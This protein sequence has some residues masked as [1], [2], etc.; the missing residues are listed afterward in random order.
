MSGIVPA[1]GFGIGNHGVVSL[2]H[3]AVNPEVAAAATEAAMRAFGRKE[4]PGMSFSLNL[5][6]GGTT[7]AGTTPMAEP[8]LT[9]TMIATTSTTRLSFARSKKTA[10]N[11]RR[12]R[13]CW[14]R[15]HRS[16]QHHWRS[17]K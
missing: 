9:T 16:R 6:L 12:H 15:N 2:D 1:G 13:D 11:S 14:T 5:N 7:M 8:I 3:A 10:N 17:N 4:P